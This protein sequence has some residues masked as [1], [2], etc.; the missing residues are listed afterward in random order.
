M[1]AITAIAL[2]VVVTIVT[3][4]GGYLIGGGYAFG[5]TECLLLKSPFPLHNQYHEYV[6]TL[7]CLFVCSWFMISLCVLINS[8]P[9]SAPFALLLMLLCVGQQLDNCL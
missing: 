2:I 4:V 7:A 9:F 6:Y 1:T 3:A 5:A 8:I